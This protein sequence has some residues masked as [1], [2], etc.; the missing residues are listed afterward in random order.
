MLDRAIDRL[1]QVIAPLVI[2]ASWLSRTASADSMDTLL[3]ALYGSI[4]IP[5]ALYRLVY[6]IV[7]S[8]SYFHGLPLFVH[9]G[10]L[11]TSIVSGAPIN[12]LILVAAAIMSAL[13]VKYFRTS[14]RGKPSPMAA[15][16]LLLVALLALL[17]YDNIVVRQAANTVKWLLIAYLATGPLLYY[18]MGRGRAHEL[19]SH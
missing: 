12:P 17:P 14:G 5:V 7:W 4:I 9:G 19:G 15:P 11:L 6:R 2:Y 8:L 10:L 3:L 16:R 1:A 18:I 13:P